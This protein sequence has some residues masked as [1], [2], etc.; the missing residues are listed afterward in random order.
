MGSLA[1]VW[2]KIP[3]TEHYEASSLGRIRSVGHYVEWKTR[4]GNT[5]RRWKDGQ[6]LQPVSHRGYLAVS[7]TLGKYRCW[8][9]H[10]LVAAAFHGPCPEGLVID[11][12]NTNKH[13]NRPDNLEY[14]TNT[15]N[16][17]RQYATGLL[18]NL[19]ETN[20]KA[21]LTR[22]S[23]IE[24]RRSAESDEALASRFGVSAGHIY[25]LRSKRKR[26]W[27]SAVA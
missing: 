6:I 12:K 13:D 2:R 8:H 23:I 5:G 16:V 1:E 10:Q 19:G 17:K 11:H 21:K 7:V 18:S 14:V 26:L 27:P 4:W 22:E 9:V 24:I 20:G 15:E 25:N 3:G